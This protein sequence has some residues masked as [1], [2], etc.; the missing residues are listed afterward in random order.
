MR[1]TVFTPTYNR[2]YIIEKLY[3]SLQR[4]TFREFEW[5][6]VDDG[7][8]DNT[9]EVV[10]AWQQEK[11]DFVIRYYKKENG[12]KCRAI[13][14]GV[15]LAQGEL[16][17]NVD[18]DDYLTDDALEKVLSWV[19]SLPKNGK[20]CGVVGNL[21][22]S[23]TETPNIPLAEP[24]RDAS[25]LE[26]YADFTDHPIDGERAC[27]FFTEIQKKYKYPEFAGENFITPAVTWNRMAHDGYLVRIF[28]DIIWVYEYQPDGLTANVGRNF[29]KNPQ[30]AG[31]WQREKAEFMGDSWRKKI[32]MWYTYYCDHTHCDEKYKL[33]LKQCAVYIGA[34]LP[35]MW[36][37]A[38][39]HKLVH[40]MK[41]IAYK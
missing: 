33:T 40:W 12:G 23:P 7:S 37:L 34:P 5:L 11:N 36:G 31:L 17:F 1:I 32:R 8:S 29:I 4:Q 3:R 14:Y 19:D 13:N 20:Y 10:S 38:V 6:I 16:F 39:V 22:T 30:G 15:D 9:Q 21:G 35:C 18:S 24:Y 27:V 26:R 25:L 41:G 2:A 28:D